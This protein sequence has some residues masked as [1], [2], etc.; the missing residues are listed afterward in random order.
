MG[1]IGGCSYTDVPYRAG[2]DMPNPGLNPLR[3]TVE[4]I[5]PLVFLFPLE[6]RSK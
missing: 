4:Q 1:L 5:L 3:C 6:Y 2:I